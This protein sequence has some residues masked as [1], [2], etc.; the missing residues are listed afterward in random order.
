[1]RERV[2]ETAMGSIHYWMDVVNAD[3]VTLVSLPG[4]TADHR[5]FDK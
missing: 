3:E 4:L 5:L 1:M 2:Y